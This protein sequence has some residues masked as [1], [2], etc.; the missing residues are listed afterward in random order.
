M[1]VCESN[2]VDTHLTYAT[3]RVQ[4]SSGYLVLRVQG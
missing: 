1:C 2:I 3:V 4:R